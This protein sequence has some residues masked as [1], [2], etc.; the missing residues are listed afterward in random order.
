MT[1]AGAVIISQMVSKTFGSSRPWP[2][3]KVARLTDLARHLRQPK[4]GAYRKVFRP[5][6]YFREIGLTL[7]ELPRRSQV[8][9]GTHTIREA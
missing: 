9:S 6:N 3:A 4:V 8:G 7:A 1:E 5:M 2:K